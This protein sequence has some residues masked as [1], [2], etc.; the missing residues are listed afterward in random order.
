MAYR[1]SAHA[2]ACLILVS[3]IVALKFLDISRNSTIFK[4]AGLLPS[5][6][7]TFDL[8]RKE[9]K[10]ANEWF[11]IGLVDLGRFRNSAYRTSS[12]V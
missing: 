8:I 9:Q 3:I 1:H 5:L 7:G 12:V 11:Q 4:F 10:V 6:S 2:L